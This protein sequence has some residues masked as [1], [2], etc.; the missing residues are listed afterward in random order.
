MNASRMRSCRKIR[1]LLDRLELKPRQRLLDIGCGWGTLGDRGRQARR[2]GRRPDPVEEQKAWAE[3]KDRRGGTGRQN[4]DP[5]PGLSRHRRAVR[6]RCFGR[7]GRGGRPALV[8]RLSR[9]HCPEPEAG[10][11]AALQFISI[12][13]RLFERYA[14]NAD[15]I[16]TYIFPGGLLL[17]EPQFEAL[18]D[19]RGLSWENREGFGRDYAETLKRWRERYDRAV[20]RGALE[21][22]R[23]AVPQSVALLFDVLRRRLSRRRDRRRAGDDGQGSLVS[24]SEVG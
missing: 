23:G 5:A 19:E 18:A 14:R 6:R 1:T 2:R 8:G 21:R 16:Q 10:G 20:A 22:L 24:W 3:A 11:R 4:R 9:Q 15:F 12:D 17:D 7:N 13:H